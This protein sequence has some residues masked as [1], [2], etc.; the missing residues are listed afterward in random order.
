MD[1]PLYTCKPIASIGLLAKTLGVHPNHLVDVAN[2]IDTSYTSFELA[3]HPKTGKVRTVL[4]AKKN[5]KRIQ[6][7][8]N[9]RIFSNVKFPAYLQGGLKSDE[10]TQRDYIENARLHSHCRTLI[11]LDVRNF[12]PNIKPIY[13][14]PVFK[15]LFR[16]ND[17]VSQIL[18]QLTTYKNSVPQGGCTS[19]YIAN[20]L[21]FNSEYHLVSKLRGQ[22]LQYSRLLD[23]ITISSQEELSKQKCEEVIK[24]VAGMLTK[25]GLKLKG[26]K[27]QTEYRSNRN[28]NLEVTG[29]WVKHRAPKVRK[30]ERRYVRQLVY[31]CEQKAKVSKTTQEY[32]EHWNR[33]S[34]LVAKLERLEHGQA[35]KYRER[36]RAILPIYSEST[37]NQ[38]LK[39]V[40]TAL[41]VPKTSHKELG[42][43]NRLN[44]IYYQLS[45]LSR[46]KRYEAKKA[47]RQLKQYYS[48]SPTKQEIWEI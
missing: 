47:R 19:S 22:G 45:I 8:I 24:L 34:G 41:K 7:R 31:V 44:K 30:E 48:S 15:Q 6:K 33:T 27:T 3:P 9:S 37:A 10:S 5:L 4:E 20:L 28:A 13:V 17:E 36:L 12:Y 26:S 32:H 25:Y 14:E 35:K 23:D 11:Q 40:S 29:V 42:R 18:T 16:F 38:V 46:T 1:K 2:K 21:F 43:V 39:S